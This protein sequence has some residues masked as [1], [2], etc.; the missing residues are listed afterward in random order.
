MPS[1]RSVRLRKQYG[2][3]AGQR[4]AVTPR[5]T[6]RFSPATAQPSWRR[7]GPEFTIGYTSGTT[8]FPKGAAP[9]AGKARSV[10][11]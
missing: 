5:H 1:E 2:A 9:G 8:G 11:M 3:T 7:H 10:W 4:N 6:L